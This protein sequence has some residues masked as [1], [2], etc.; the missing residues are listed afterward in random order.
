[1]TKSQNYREIPRRY[2]NGLFGTLCPSDERWLFV[3][4]QEL[5]NIAQKQL[6]KTPFAM[7]FVTTMSEDSV[8]SSEQELPQVDGVVGIG[9]GSCLDYAKYVAWK[10]NIPLILA[11]SIVSV[12]ACL[13]DA[14]AVRRD[15]RVHYMGTAYPKE[16]VVD[17]DLIGAAPAELNRAGAGD[18]LSIHTALF[19]WNLSHERNGEAYDNQIAEESR[20]L[21]K[22]LS[23]NV[24]DIRD[25]TPDGIRTLIEL[26]WSEVVLCYRM[27]NSRPEEGSEHFWAYNLEFLTVRSFAH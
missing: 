13:T 14:V 7:H 10:R 19:D 22:I 11:P 24:D 3:T 2:G 1:M 21:L 27:G 25:A 20:H 15:G 8:E 18:I 23:E 17:F 12:D 6:A 26:F 4:M 9:G 5:W 16:V